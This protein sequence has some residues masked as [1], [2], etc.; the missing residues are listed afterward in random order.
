MMQAV[1]PPFS[2]NH[3]MARLMHVLASTTLLA[4]ACP[5]H[6]D[7]NLYIYTWTDYTSPQLIQKFEKET[8]IKVSVDTFDSNETLL[9]RL[10]S[11][12]TGYDI[13][14][15]SSDFIPLFIDEH[16]VQK[17]EVSKWP[18][19]QNIDARWRSPFWDKNNDYSIPFGWGVTAY[20]VNTKYIKAPADSLKLLF[21]PPPE[22]KGKVGMMSAPTEVASMAE[23]YLGMSP[24]QTDVANMKK[25]S[26]VLEAQAPSVKV[27][28]SDG[29]IERTAS[30]ETWIQQTWNGDA[31][32][33]RMVNPDL[34]FVFPKEGAVGW[35]DNLVVPVGAKNVENAKHFLRFLLKPENAGISANFTH[36]ASPISG[37]EPYLDKE[38]REA[39]EMKVPADLKL[40]FTPPCSAAAIK[41]IDK[42]WTRL[43]R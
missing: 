21:E 6:A 8:G 28:A 34:K 33:A 25:V 5:A 4:S 43:R 11:G 27:Y 3:P 20:L 36:Y 1:I 24:C 35:M 42:V 13:A 12:S 38:L 26:S 16:L 22:A 32:R 23:I 17:I 14:I 30:G 41:L 7:G 19:Y 29:I 10:K 9:A 39:P 18:E 2:W 31:A 15:G 40:S 37:V